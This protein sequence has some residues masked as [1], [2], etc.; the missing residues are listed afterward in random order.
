M[1]NGFC[2]S[3]PKL[4]SSLS[5]SKRLFVFK[6]RKAKKLTFIVHFLG[7]STVLRA[8]WTLP[9]SMNLQHFHLNLLSAFP[10]LS[11]TSV[12]LLFTTILWN[13]SCQG[14]MT[15]NPV[16]VFQSSSYLTP[17]QHSALEKI[18]SSFVS[19]TLG[20]LV[21][22]PLLSLTIGFI[23]E[24]THL[25]QE[26]LG[27]WEIGTSALFRAHIT[28]H[29]VSVCLLSLWRSTCLLAIAI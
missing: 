8:L 5:V 21:F 25:S 26:E 24:G 12:W 7:A 10:P 18:F 3:F 14:L 28:H 22:L 29:C 2:S 20:V 16:D 27:P 4:S 19:L 6:M 11:P 15:L 9:A 1:E 23:L 17:R 13:C